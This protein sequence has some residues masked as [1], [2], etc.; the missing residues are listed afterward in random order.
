MKVRRQRAEVGAGKAG[1]PLRA[2]KEQDFMVQIAQEVYRVVLFAVF[3]LQTYVAG[4]IPIPLVGAPPPLSPLSI[5]HV[6]EGGAIPVLINLST[7]PA[8]SCHPPVRRVFNPFLFSFF[9]LLT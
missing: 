5:P 3:M 6:C 9:P 4:I 2:D 1:K 7:H 8:P